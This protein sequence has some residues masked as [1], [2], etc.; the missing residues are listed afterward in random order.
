MPSGS[1]PNQLN[2]FIKLKR[3]KILMSQKELGLKLGY[4]NG[5]YISNMERGMCPVPL[6]KLDKIIYLLKLNPNEVID[7]IQEDHLSYLKTLL[8]DKSRYRKKTK[9]K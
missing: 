3:E 8:F 2:L 7:I 4:R 5:Q 1:K 9:S 6:E